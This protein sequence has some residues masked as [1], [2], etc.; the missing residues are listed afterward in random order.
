MRAVRAECRGGRTLTDRRKRPERSAKGRR[1]YVSRYYAIT[2]T[3]AQPC[4]SDDTDRES[5]VTRSRLG[6]VASEDATT[7]VRTS[8]R[9]HR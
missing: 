5:R 3:C 2:T 9:R 8:S 6:L 7:T 1:G 4:D